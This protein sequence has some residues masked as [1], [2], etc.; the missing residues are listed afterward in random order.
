MAIPSIALIPSGYKASKLYSVL[1][2]NG[3]ADL[4]VVRNSTANRIN[5]DGLIESMAVN[6]PLLDHSNGTCPSLLLQPQSTNLITYPLS[7]GNSYWTKSGASIEGDAS[8]AGSEATTNGSFT[9]SATGWTLSS[10][11]TYSDNSLLCVSGTS[12]IQTGSLTIGKTYKVTVTIS[13][14]V[15][16]IMRIKL[17]TST[18]DTFASTTTFQL[19]ANG[20]N[21]TIDGLASISANIDSISV[22]EVQ[23]FSAPSVDNPTSA[24]KLVEDTSTGGHLIERSTSVTSGAT[25]TFSVF[26]KK[27][28]NN[29]CAINSQASGQGYYFDLVNGVVLGVIGSAPNDYEITPLANDWFKISIT[30]TMPSTSSRFFVFNSK[31]GT[32]I[33]YTGDGTSGVYIFGA[34]LEQQS[35]PTSL[36]LPATEGSTTTRLKDEVSKTGLSAEIN[37][38]EGTLFVEVAALADD[39]TTRQFEL[40]SGDNTNYIRFE[41][42]STTNLIYGI[43]KKISQQAA[44]SFTLADSTNFNKIAIK[45][46][47]NDFALW[48]NGVEVA[49]DLNGAVPTGLNSLNFN[50][51]GTNNIYANYNQL[52]VFKTALTD[53]ELTALTTI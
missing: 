31:D 49:T 52:Q 38:V 11:I 19:Y 26:I 39:L 14:Y 29:F 18:S 43:V 15:S 16:G 30:A 22:K 48:V 9:G 20:T 40:T 27:G 36:M 3:N 51:N 47:V 45:W 53:A 32:S 37:S 2:T 5:K 13:S 25:V 28:E 44:L 21:I 8:T 17:G 35:Y 50:G 46:K 42:A 7:F 23:G 10:G 4:T 1:P 12:A 6:V 24:F 34:Q 33:S 41:F